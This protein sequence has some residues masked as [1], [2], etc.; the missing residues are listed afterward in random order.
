MIAQMG[1][2]IKM[3]PNTQATQ[4][5][6]VQATPVNGAT[7]ATKPTM[8]QLLARIAELEAASQAGITYKCHGAG[9][10]Y[11]D[12]QGKEQIGKGA[13]SMSGLGRFPVTLY[14]SQWDRLV[15]EVK[16][17]S[18]DAALLR[19]KDKLAVKGSK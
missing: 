3:N 17:G 16:N 2:D 9:E 10:K 13:M 12:G 18:V 6:A 4:T 15:A 7:V 1:E 5:Q 8:E 14:K 19:F 11:T